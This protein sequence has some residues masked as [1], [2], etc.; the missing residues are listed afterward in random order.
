MTPPMT[1]TEIIVT[2]L[3]VLLRSSQSLSSRLTLQ[4][5]QM[6]RQSNP[7]G[8]ALDGGK[9]SD[10][11]CRYSMK[12]D[13]L[14]AIDR[15]GGGFTSHSNTQRMQAM[16]WHA[17][18]LELEQEIAATVE[19]VDSLRQLR[20]NAI[21]ELEPGELS[22]SKERK[23]SDVHCLS[24]RAMISQQRTKLQELEAVKL[25]LELQRSQLQEDEE[26]LRRSADFNEKRM[27]SVHLIRECMLM[28]ENV[29][30]R[31]IPD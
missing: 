13:V 29:D 26:S 24:L 31:S 23:E 22:K 9:A 11:V 1:Q 14:G 21:R 16:H 20:Q 27:G 7:G 17:L 5:L 4:M 6:L 10:D 18:A 19:R 25:Q 15:I 28:I 3:A 8:L 2:F 30:L 12:M